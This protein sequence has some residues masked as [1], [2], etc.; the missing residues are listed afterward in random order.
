MQRVNVAQ[1]TNGCTGVLQSWLADKWHR[2]AVSLWDVHGECHHSVSCKE[3][4]ASMYHPVYRYHLT[5]AGENPALTS[6][7]ILQ[8]VL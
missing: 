1:Q 6:A 4:K 5:L 2:A 7:L 3:L 8:S